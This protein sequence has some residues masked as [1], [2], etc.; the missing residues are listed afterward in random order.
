M[1]CIVCGIEI[2]TDRPGAGMTCS[3]LCRDAAY[4]EKRR[5]KEARRWRRPSRLR[6]AKRRLERKRAERQADPAWLAWR[7][8]VD[9]RK[10]EE[11][12]RQ[13]SFKIQRQCR[14]CGNEF[15]ARMRSQIFCSP[16]CR[17]RR[18]AKLQQC[19]A[20]GTEFLSYADHNIHCSNRCRWKQKHDLDRLRPDYY[21]RERERH[22]REREKLA[23]II[24]EL[25]TF[26]WIDENF[27][28]IV[29]D[30]PRVLPVLYSAAPPREHGPHPRSRMAVA[31]RREQRRRARDERW[32]VLRGQVV[33]VD[34]GGEAVVK[35]VDR[36][37]YH[38]DY[39]NKHR[40]RFRQSSAYWQ[41]QFAER[42]ERKLAKQQ[43]PEAQRQEQRRLYQRQ[44]HRDNRQRAAELH[45]KKRA[46]IAALDQI[47]PDPLNHTQISG[48]DL[49]PGRSTE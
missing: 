15:L 5:R 26:G 46:L 48:S 3:T 4:R 14:R 24:G 36:A 29:P 20:C 21:P 41:G 13:T 43:R 40:D 12:E 19:V 1:N 28:I 34:R 44:Y 10:Q 2:A 30:A 16:E 22:R 9:R 8:D 38:R 45:R 7:A 42:R 27:D 17:P 25:R 47:A 6:R 49:G 33:F 39:M 18:G 35:I 31:L 11:K 37:E 32:S 23:A